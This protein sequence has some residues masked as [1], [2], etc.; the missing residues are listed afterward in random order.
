MQGIFHLYRL[1]I[2]IKYCEFKENTYSDFLAETD[3]LSMERIVFENCLMDD[4]E[5]VNTVDEH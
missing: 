1:R 5:T 4:G 3:S 2:H